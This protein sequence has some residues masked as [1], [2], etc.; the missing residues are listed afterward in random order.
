MDGLM[1][2]VCSE[3]KCPTLVR[4][5]IRQALESLDERSSAQG[6]WVV[7]KRNFGF[8]VTGAI[9]GGLGVV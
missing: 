5:D 6:S 3:R 1:E 8:I 7:L 2:M 4:L 9:A